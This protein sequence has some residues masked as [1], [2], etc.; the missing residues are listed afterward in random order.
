VNNFDYYNWVILP[1]IIFIARIGDVTL[2]TIRHVL[3]SRG[4]KNLSPVFG[5]FEVFIWIIVASQVMKQAT[6]WACYVGWAGGFAAGNYIGLLI[7]ER[8]ALGMQIIRVITH[9]ECS[10]LITKLQEA[11]HGTT[12]IDAHGA[13][14]PVKV[15]L[16]IV[17][18]KNID[19]ILK[20]IRKHNPAAF[21][22]IEDIRDVNRGIFTKRNE[23][24]FKQILPRR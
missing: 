15:I 23:S 10:T 13:T 9:E 6:N 18:R 3:T 21:F 24:F 19:P 1:L 12:V 2:G 11:N 14:G 22:S 16:T 4:K 20:I 8:I 17:K 7:E 5:F